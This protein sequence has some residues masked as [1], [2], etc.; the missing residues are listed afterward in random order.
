MPQTGRAIVHPHKREVLDS[1]HALGNDVG[2]ALLGGVLLVHPSI[3]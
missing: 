3:P 1:P 2:D